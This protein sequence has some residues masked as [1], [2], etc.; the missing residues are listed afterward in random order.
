MSAI[1]TFKHKY[2]IGDKVK[3]RLDDSIIDITITN[4][5]FSLTDI[6]FYTF[7]RVSHR[8]KKGNVLIDSYVLSETDIID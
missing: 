2:I 6:G 8:N 5:E 7:Y 3:M 4:I 1:T